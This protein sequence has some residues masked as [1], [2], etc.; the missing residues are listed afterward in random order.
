MGLY[1]TDAGAETYKQVQQC[2]F[3]SFSTKG[4]EQRKEDVQNLV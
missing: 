4:N 2:L 1:R 3:L